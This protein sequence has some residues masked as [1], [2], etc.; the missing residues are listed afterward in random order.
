MD[1]AS[2]L[3][4]INIGVISVEDITL[5]IGEIMLDFTVDVTFVEINNTMPEIARKSR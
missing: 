5:T 4:V 3:E 1:R 2:L